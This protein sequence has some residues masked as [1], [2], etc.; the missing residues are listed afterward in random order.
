MYIYI[1]IRSELILPYI[2]GDFHP[3]H[4]QEKAG[5]LLF[6]FFKDN[7]VDVRTI[8]FGGTWKGAARGKAGCSHWPGRSMKN[9]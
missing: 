3:D 4:L 2:Y 5:G 7:G 1:Y 8:P 9:P 6:A